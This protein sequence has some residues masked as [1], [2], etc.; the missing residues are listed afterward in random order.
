MVGW[1]QLATPT[2]QTITLGKIIFVEEV[3]KQ[4]DGQVFGS[5]IFFPVNGTTCYRYRY[6]IATNAWSTLSTTNVPAAFGT[7]AYVCFLSPKS[8]NYEGGYHSRC[9]ENYHKSAV[10]AVGATSA[11]V[12]A[13]PTALIADTVVDFGKA[14]LTLA[15]GC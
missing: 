5:I 3:G 6:D 2:T 9:F 12:T 1:L 15:S 8:N 11:S 4:R 14:E 10:A 7:D 13:L